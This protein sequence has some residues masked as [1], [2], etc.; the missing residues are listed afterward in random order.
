MQPARCEQK[1]TLLPVCSCCVYVQVQSCQFSMRKKSHLG[2]EKSPG[3]LGYVRDY[4]TQL[5]RDYNEQLY[6][7][8]PIH[9]PV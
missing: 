1:G 7:R 6:I 4:T 9:Q 2:N 8:I 5:Y 3:C